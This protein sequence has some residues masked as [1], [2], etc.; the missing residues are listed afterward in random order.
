V[1]Q[2]CIF[3]WRTFECNLSKTCRIVILK[4]NSG[5][6]PCFELV[7]DYKTCLFTSCIKNQEKVKKIQKTRGNNQEINM[8]MISK[9]DNILYFRQ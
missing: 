2:K 4:K 6:F 8:K 5:F 7:F 3:P 9:I 1:T